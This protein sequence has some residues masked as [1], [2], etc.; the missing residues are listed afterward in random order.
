LLLWF[1]DKSWEG[2]YLKEEDLLF[3]FYV[4]ASFLILN[5]MG[6][7]LLLTEKG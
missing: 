6:I 3:K 1:K 5:A 7:I 2:P 4:L